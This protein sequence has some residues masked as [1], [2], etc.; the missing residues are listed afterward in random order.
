ME[1]RQNLPGSGNRTDPPT[2]N[3]DSLP[4]VVLANRYVR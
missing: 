1:N 2:F 4:D 3:G